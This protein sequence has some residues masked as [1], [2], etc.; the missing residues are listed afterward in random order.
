MLKEDKHVN[1]VFEKDGKWL[2]WNKTCTDLL[3]PYPDEETAN[4]EFKKHYEKVLTET[5]R[6]CYEV[7]QYAAFSEYTGHLSGKEVIATIMFLFGKDT[8]NKIIDVLREE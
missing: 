1:N 8:V 6:L 2:F 3:G 7:M 4:I 5:E